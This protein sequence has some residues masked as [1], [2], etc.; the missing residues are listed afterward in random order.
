MEPYFAGQ[1]I[2]HPHCPLEHVSSAFQSLD[3]VRALHQTVVSLRTALEDAHREIDNLKK[4]IVIK[5]DIDDG[6]IFHSQRQLKEL[7]DR[8]DETR[9]LFVKLPP[10]SDTELTVELPLEIESIEKPKDSNLKQKSETKKVDFVESASS[11][12]K[13]IIPVSSRI[14]P[15][16]ISAICPTENSI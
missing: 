2:D 8:I 6:K 4:Q 11:D 13:N 3:T 7:K 12:K 10:E 5:S 16:S 1:T 9:E 15:F 14:S